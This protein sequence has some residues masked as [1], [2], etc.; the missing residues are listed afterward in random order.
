MSQ[1]APRAQGRGYLPAPRPAGG[2]ARELVHAPRLERT[3][4]AHRGLPSRAPENTM[5]SFLAAAR[6]GATWIETDVDL[7]ADGTAVLIH[8][9]AL[10]RTT[11]RSGSIYTLQA[12]DLASIDAGS[13][14]DPRFAG[15]RL[16]VLD[17]FIDLLSEHGLH[18]N[19]ELKPNEQGA[20]RS[21]LLVDTVARALERLDPAC[22]VLVS[23]FSQPLLMA[24]HQRHPRY[25]TAVLYEAG[26]IRPDWL[27]VAELCGAGCIHP[28]DEGLS[29]SMVA[30][31]RRAGYGVNV[32]TVNSAARAAE[33]FEWGCT[34]VFTDVADE[35]G[36]LE[37][38]QH[39]SRQ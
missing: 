38:S 35:F 27:S 36:A 9:T 25:A 13:W 7:L 2:G 11:D 19:I 29:E 23:S 28:Q 3:V 17:A 34:G 4:I 6:A 18:A 14:F 32:W 21:L 12:A 26:A 33:L 16:P 5:A 10:D 37:G 1:D 24:F 22:Q 15:E 20:V 30:L 39:P 8:D 31:A